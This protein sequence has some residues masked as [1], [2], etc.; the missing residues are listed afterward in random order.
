VPKEVLVAFVQ[1]CGMKFKDKDALRT[2]IRVHTKEKPFAC[3]L[4][5]YRYSRVPLCHLQ[6]Q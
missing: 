2:H 5:N 4:C 6:V 3:H 1:I